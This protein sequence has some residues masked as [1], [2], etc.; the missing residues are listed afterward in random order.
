M[1]K[2]AKQNIELLNFADNGLKRDLDFMLKM[3]K[4]N[5]YAIRYFF[6]KMLT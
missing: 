5:S 6:D 2:V 1:L 4:V 3:I